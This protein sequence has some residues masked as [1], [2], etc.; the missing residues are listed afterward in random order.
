MALVLDISIFAKSGFKTMGVTHEGS[1]TNTSAKH[2]FYK[3][4]VAW[5]AST[6]FLGKYFRAEIAKYS[7]IWKITIQFLCFPR[8]HKNLELT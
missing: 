3:M 2:H 4:T 8:P 5:D 6:F 7:W 1:E